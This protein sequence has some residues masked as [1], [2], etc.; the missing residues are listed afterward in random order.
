[1]QGIKELL[2]L[3]SKQ[4]IM[5]IHV[6]DSKVQKSGVPIKVQKTWI[7]IQPY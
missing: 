7:T 6:I 4:V 5:G 1:M 3:K 2:H